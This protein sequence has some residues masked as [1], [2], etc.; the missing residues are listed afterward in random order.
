LGFQALKA[1]DRVFSSTIPLNHMI[2][3]GCTDQENASSVRKDA[4]RTIEVA[5]D[6][7]AP[8]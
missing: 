2:T 5:K 3:S 4:R 7:I 8:K 6:C 1:K